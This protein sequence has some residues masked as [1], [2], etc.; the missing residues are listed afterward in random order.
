[1]PRR[2]DS[3]PTT[4]TTKLGEERT[5][6]ARYRTRAV[7][8][9]ITNINPSQELS[10]IGGNRLPSVTPLTLHSNG[11]EPSVFIEGPSSLVGRVPLQLPATFPCVCASKIGCF[12]SPRS[13]SEI[14]AQFLCGTTSPTHTATAVP[15]RSISQTSTPALDAGGSISNRPARPLIT[16][17]T[18]EDSV[19][20]PCSPEACLACGAQPEASKAYVHELISFLDAG[21]ESNLLS[22]LRMAGIFTSRH[23]HLLIQMSREERD[24]F[25]RLLSHGY[26]NEVTAMNLK[27]RL[28]EYAQQSALPNSSSLGEGDTIPEPS[29]DIK[30]ELV[31]RACLPDRFAQVMQIS[32]DKYEAL[33]KTISVCFKRIVTADPGGSYFH[34]ITE[35]Q[36]SSFVSEV[37]QVHPFLTHYANSWPL[38]VYIKSQMKETSIPPQT[39]RKPIFSSSFQDKVLQIFTCP[40]R[41]HMIPGFSSY[42]IPTMLQ[43]HFRLLRMEE[44]IPAAMLIG[45]RSNEDFVR[46]IEMNDE[47]VETLLINTKS[48]KLSLLHRYLL[49]ISFKKP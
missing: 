1:M 44:L 3:E 19:S 6:L 49:Q 35:G 7:L 8:G 26:L 4:K 30:D 18:A 29:G 2:G 41:Q 5:S 27:R 12:S 37:S 20:S 39:L 14:P 45:I 24:G 31:D 47:L 28:E 43:H 40:V 25:F 42:P 36:W 11:T 38:E 15:A 17:S 22:I 9:D 10:P 33:V 21:R 46:I 48:T 34:E 23:L 16:N 13:Q 32:R